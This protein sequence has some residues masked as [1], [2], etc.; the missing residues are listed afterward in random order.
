[1]L[2]AVEE[3]S[4]YTIKKIQ[5]IDHL[6]ATTLKLV[7]EKLP[8]IRKE[9][10]EKIFEQPYISPKTLLDQNIRSINTAKKYLSQMEDLGVMVSEKIGREIVY[11]N[12]DLLNLLSET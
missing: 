8:Q 11:L 6:Q 12:I 4:K 9:V 5:E 2:N 7:H 10:I 3:T 1:M